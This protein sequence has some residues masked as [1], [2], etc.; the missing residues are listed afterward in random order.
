[1]RNRLVVSLVFLFLF[2]TYAPQKIYLNGIFNI[3]EIIVENNFILKDEEIKKD[4]IFL[5]ETNLLSLETDK[6]EKIV[7]NKTFIKSFE[8]K[9][10]YPNKLII[11][12]FEEKPIVILLYKKEKYY[13]S[14]SMKL[15]D[16]TTLKDYEN[17]PIV[18][19]G[20]DHFKIFYNNLKKI[21]FPFDIVK[22]FYFFESKRWDL[23]TYANKLI[24]LPTMNYN[25]SLESFMN[26]RKE[27]NFDKFSVFDYR[28]KNQLILK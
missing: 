22:K 11:K 23:E 7:K 1:M 28:I 24:K 8:I 27:N 26:L 14:E 21:N 13:V 5:Y 25:K 17:L 3:K 19:G 12:I 6:I 16:F 18:F 15:I 20:K 2:T 9:K 10:I 4:L